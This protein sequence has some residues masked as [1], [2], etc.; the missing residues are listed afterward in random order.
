MQ[1]PIENGYFIDYKE[2]SSG[3]YAGVLYGPEI[4]NGS[5]AAI[6][7]TVDEI[8]TTL[9]GLTYKAGIPDSVWD[10]LGYVI[11]DYGFI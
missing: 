5:Q 10:D 8:L 6:G 3:I 9:K 4:D 7:H 2:V 1:F 11:K